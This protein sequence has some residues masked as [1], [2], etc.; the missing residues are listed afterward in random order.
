MI[1]KIVGYDGSIVFDTSKP[2]G[3]PRKLVDPTRL[4]DMGWKPSIDLETGLTDLY[5]RWQQSMLTSTN[6]AP[7][8]SAA[9]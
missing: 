7:I 2:D 5:M 1:A 4:Q 9:R 3:T 8:A 6:V